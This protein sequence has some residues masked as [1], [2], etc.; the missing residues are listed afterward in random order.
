MDGRPSRGCFPVD[1]RPP[2]PAPL[3]TPPFEATV[4]GWI[5]VFGA[6]PAELAGGA[7]VANQ[8]PT[9]IAAP[10]LMLS[11]TTTSGKPE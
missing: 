4:A 8:A 6:A 3:L 9:A 2:K 11:C 7:V 1:D 10:V 5:V